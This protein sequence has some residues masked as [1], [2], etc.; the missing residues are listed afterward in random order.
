MGDRGLLVGLVADRELA[1]AEHDLHAALLHAER[2]LQRARADH[3][4]IADAAGDLDRVGLDLAGELAVG[5]Q[6][7]DL[8][9]AGHDAAGGDVD[10]RTGDVASTLPITTIGQL[11]DIVPLNSVPSS[12]RVCLPVGSPFFSLISPRSWGC[13]R[14][15]PGC[16]HRGLSRRDDLDA[17]LTA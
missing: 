13:Y 7:L 4:A 3:R 1:L 5:P 15:S 14:G 8:D 2:D 11:E 16:R 6:L 10:D 17:Q 9:D 12:T